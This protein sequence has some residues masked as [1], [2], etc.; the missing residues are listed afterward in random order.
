MNIP[1]YD[2]DLMN[3]VYQDLCF[4]C[5]Y[6]YWEGCTGIHV[7]WNVLTCRKARKLY[8]K[9]EKEKNNES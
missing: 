4:G 9:L 5:A 8:E 1:E 7:E 3:R 6:R 2:R